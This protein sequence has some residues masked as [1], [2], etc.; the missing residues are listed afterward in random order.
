MIR[1]VTSFVNWIMTIHLTLP[2]D[3]QAELERRAAAAG[4]DPV[5]FV[6]KV[7][8]ERLTEPEES[9]SRKLSHEQWRR[10]FRNW[11]DSQVSRNPDFDDSRES[12]YP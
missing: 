2:S 11:V 1:I 7:V 8:Q 12:I 6:L 9:A 10:R 3:Q 5:H 4:I